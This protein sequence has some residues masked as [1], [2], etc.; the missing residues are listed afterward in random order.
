MRKKN[1]FCREM[2]GEI[3]RKKEF[4]LGIGFFFF[5]YYKEAEIKGTMGKV[6]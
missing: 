3:V 4:D 5:F 1:F 6:Q 2:N